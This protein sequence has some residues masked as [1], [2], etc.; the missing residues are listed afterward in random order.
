VRVRMGR[1]RR[2][3]HAARSVLMCAAIQRVQHT[4]KSVNTAVCNCCWYVQVGETA[5]RLP[6]TIILSHA[7]LQESLPQ[8]SPDRVAVALFA[9]TSSD[10]DWQPDS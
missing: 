2:V 10:V 5:A 4:K 9:L 6:T 8:I 1:G 3:Q 7:M